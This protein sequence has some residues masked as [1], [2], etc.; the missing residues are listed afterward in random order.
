LAVFFKLVSA[1]ESVFGDHE[2]EE[3]EEEEEEEED[4]D[5]VKEDIVGC[6][7]LLAP[8]FFGVGR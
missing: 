3:E 8:F 6:W 4:D 1:A 2:S 5:L 7:L